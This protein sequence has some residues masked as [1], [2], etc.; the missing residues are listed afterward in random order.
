MFFVDFLCLVLRC[1][2]SSVPSCITTTFNTPVFYLSYARKHTPTPKTKHVIPIPQ[3]GVPEVNRWR[4][5]KVNS[6]VNRLASI[7]IKSP[8]C[9][10]ANATYSLLMTFPRVSLAL[11]CFRILQRLMWLVFLTNCVV[12]YHVFLDVLVSRMQSVRNAVRLFRSR[13]PAAWFHHL[14]GNAKIGLLP[15]FQHLFRA[16]FNFWRGYFV[17]LIVLYII[18]SRCN[19]MVFILVTWDSQIHVRSWRKI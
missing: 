17:M 9:V 19:N 8:S 4:I 6:K 1:Q 11:C 3:K 14:Y 13:S 16:N 15:R 2:W 7:K 5:P 18:W 10:N 12:C